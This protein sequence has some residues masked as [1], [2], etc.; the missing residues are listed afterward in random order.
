M[1][2]YSLCLSVRSFILKFGMLDMLKL[3]MVIH[4]PVMCNVKSIAILQSEPKVLMYFFYGSF[5]PCQ[6]FYH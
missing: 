6:L 3:D 1:L 5:H 2:S 4:E